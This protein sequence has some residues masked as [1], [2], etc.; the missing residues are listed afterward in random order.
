MHWE[1]S[2]FLLDK[3]NQKELFRFLSSVAALQESVWDSNHKII[4]LSN[5]LS[6]GSGVKLWLNN[7]CSTVTC[8]SSRTLLY[9]TDCWAVTPILHLLCNASFLSW[10]G[11]WHWQASPDH[12]FKIIHNSFFIAC[13]PFLEVMTILWEPR[14]NN[15]L[16]D[17]A[18]A[19][20]R[21]STD[22]TE[23]NDK[24]N[25]AGIIKFGWRQN[26]L[27]S[28]P[29]PDTNYCDNYILPFLQN[30]PDALETLGLIQPTSQ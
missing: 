30:I 29:S 1:K 17:G 24:R 2:H 8:N 6:G 16:Q 12:K 11:R 13:W 15:T 4:N 19:T 18:S 28:V 9:Q 23:F 3:S 5:P 26:A 25:L 14:D 7:I 20:E 27:H 22:T 10:S 21:R